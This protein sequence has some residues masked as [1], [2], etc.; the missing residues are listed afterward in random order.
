[1]T[2]DT[3]VEGIHYLP[4]S[5]A[6]AVGWKLVAVNLSDLAAKGATPMGCLLNYSL[7]G[8]AAWDEAFLSGL[9]DALQQYDMPLLGGDTVS[10]TAGHPRSLTLTAVGTV[11]QG[12]RVPDRRNAKAGDQ[13]WVS[14]TIG[15]AGQGL[16][17]L[18]LGDTVGGFLIERHLRPTPRMA[19]GKALLGVCD[20]MMDV[21]DGLL[22][23]VQ[24]MSK[25]SG[26]AM[27]IELDKVPISDSLRAMLGGGPGGVV[28]ASSAGDDYEL[29]FTAPSDKADDIRAI[30]RNCRVRLSC[31]G[32]CIPGAD[33]SLGWNGKTVPL[34]ANIGYRHN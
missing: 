13:I 2:T 7:S 18:T 33:L 3:M 34:P 5:P 19:L 26:L 28:A 30:A 24:R 9:S 4:E 32:H 6:D 16:K 11:A 17:L 22:I 23:D 31:I 27:R 20:A 1:M 21:S 15:D 14:G 29:L 12:S 10:K 8:E 25:A